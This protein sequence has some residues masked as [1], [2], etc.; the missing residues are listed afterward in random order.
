MS[1]LLFSLP[2]L[3]DYSI[4]ST[5]FMFPPCL[6]QEVALLFLEIEACALRMNYSPDTAAMGKVTFLHHNSQVQSP[7]PRD[8]CCERERREQKK[9]LFQLLQH[10][11][12]R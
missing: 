5:V 1:Q 3:P 6:L 12:D 4:F 11:P 9:A 7:I 2:L 10:R 8:E